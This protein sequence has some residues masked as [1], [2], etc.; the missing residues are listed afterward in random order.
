MSK[1]KVPSGAAELT[2][3]GAWLAGYHAGLRVGQVASPPPSPTKEPESNTWA[4]LWFGATLLLACALVACVL[5]DPICDCAKPRPEAQPLETIPR[6][7]PLVVHDPGA[8]LLPANWRC[9]V[10]RS[11][12]RVGARPFGVVVA[13]QI[14]HERR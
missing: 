4:I 14:I 9:G 2:P 3:A 13:S 12:V 10:G 8:M 7:S 11:R 6:Q 1:R 5:T